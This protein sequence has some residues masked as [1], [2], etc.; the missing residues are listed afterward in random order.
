[1]EDCVHLG[2][3][4]KAMT[5]VLVGQLIAEGKVG[6]G[7]TMGEIFAERR[8]RIHDGVVEATVAEVM[9]HRAGLVGNLRWGDYARAAVGL[10][11]QR[12][13]AV[14]EALM[15]APA[16]GRGERGVYMYSNAGY[17]VLGAVVE[18]LR[19]AAW[20]EVVRER[21]FRPLGMDSAGFG[22]LGRREGEAWGHGVEGGEVI[23][24]AI[25]N[26]AV[27]RP[28]GGVHCSMTDWGKFVAMFLRGEEAGVMTREMC[29]MLLT[30]PPRM[31][32]KAYAGGWIAAKR[33]GD[34][35]AYTHAGSNTMWFSVA[36]TWP[37]KGFA[38]LA[39]ANCGGE[40]ARQAC[41]KV[42][43]RLREG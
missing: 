4:T 27:M 42:C 24:R 23:A 5:A 30:P 3:N 11:E 6:M 35:R 38:V 2:S 16:A 31:P 32:G 34:A 29:A 15:G 10:R 37:E 43:A 20:E 19:G 22:A 21:L 1:M 26:P 9:W 18:K 36:W 40:E 13:R 8:W 33:A 12:E 25:D 39:A 7:T 41:E 28:A 14:A 17:V